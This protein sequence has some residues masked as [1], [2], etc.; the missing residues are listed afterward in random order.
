[1]DAFQD[2][3]YSRPNNEVLLNR[4]GATTANE[5][6]LA[7]GRSSGLIGQL[8]FGIKPLPG[9]LDAAHLKRIHREL[10]GTIY[11]WAGET[12]AWGQFQGQKQTKQGTLFFAPYEQ[13]DTRLNLLS[14]QLREE[15]QL[16]GLDK[17]QFVQRLAYYADQYNYV[18][19]FREGNGRTLQVVVAAIGRG[20]GYDVRLSEQQIQERY[21]PARNVAILRKNALHPTENLAPLRDLFFEA[22]TPT[23]GAPAE[24]L[25]H[26]DQ[27]RPL[28]AP[29][30]AMLQAEALRAV[31]VGSRE[32]VEELLMQRLAKHHF[33]VTPAYL[34]QAQGQESYL[35]VRAQQVQ[36][37]PA[38]WPELRQQLRT[39]VEQ[40][41]ADPNLTRSSRAHMTQLRTAGMEL[42]KNTALTPPFREGEIP[43]EPLL[44]L[45]KSLDELWKRGQ[46]EK[47]LR[48]EPSDS[49][50]V[51]LGQQQIPVQL[52][53]KRQPNGEV[54]MRAILPPQVR[55]ALQQ[56]LAN[57][58]TPQPPG[59]AQAPP[60]PTPPPPNKPEPDEP[61]SPRRGRR[62]K[63]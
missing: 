60:A 56:Q 2:L 13:I 58:A 17:A 32:L 3:R 5:L 57:L 11:P 6:R 42:D 43:A 59:P 23:P 55:E 30:P 16:R 31:I 26:P 21:N 47:L 45:G 51:T 9:A 62:P 48:G 33:A 24:Q 29:H 54:D 27:A 10:L 28:G 7:E 38:T 1:M 52:L 46:V 18:H 35:I 36:R 8:T 4:I 15:N 14:D 34:Q 63:L 41:E 50:P 22:T 39:Q 44:L 61:P 53:L 19:A 12:R 25:R 40:V 49:L 20:A 37:E